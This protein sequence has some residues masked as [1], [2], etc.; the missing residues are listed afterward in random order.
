GFILEHKGG[1]GLELRPRLPYI[2]VG[3]LVVTIVVIS[4]MLVLTKPTTPR[5]L[6]VVVYA[7]S[8]T[9]T[10]IDPSVE[11]D[12]GLIVIG[13]VYETLTYYDHAT[14]E[15]KPRLAV[16]W[17]VN[18]DGTEWMFYLRR[19]VVFHDGTPFN[20]T[21]AKLSIER[22]RDIYRAEG[23]GLG[24]I[25]DAVEEIE[26]VDEYTIKFKLSYPQRLDL[27]AASTYAAYMFSPTALEKSGA[28]NYMDRKLED[29]FNAGNAIGTG[30][31]RLVHYDPKHEIKLEK[32]NEWWGW[33]EVSNPDAPDIIIIKIE[34]NPEAQYH[35]LIA[36]EIDIACCIPRRTVPL[37]I[38][39]GYRILNM[40]TFRNFL[41]FFNT[42]RYPT[43]ITYF[44]LAIAHTV[45][46]ELFVQTALMGM[47]YPAS[48]VIPRGFPGYVEK[49]SYEYNVTKAKE[50][51]EL[52]NV[53]LPLTIEVL[54]QVDYEETKAFAEFLKSTIE[55]ELGIR[56][57]LNPQSWEALRD[58]ARGIWENPEKTPHIIIADWWPTML[59]PYDYL[60]TMFHSESKAWNFAGY[61][62][63]ELDELIDEAWYLEGVDYRKA[64][65]MYIQAQ[66][67]IYREAV[68]IGLWD[69][70]RPYAYSPRLEVPGE[71]LS[72]FYMYVIRFELVKVRS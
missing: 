61:E 24:Y 54:Y 6:K 36:G 58:I 8:D 64:M 32:F 28:L 37:A 21:A 44:R 11:D 26:I 35:G 20:A 27:L 16:R 10:G 33:R 40:S 41:L 55:R 43:N 71:A 18:E 69:D 15:V 13:T 49:L 38:E 52:S 67:L 19:D 29:W 1:L 47:A 68:A 39:K 17:E 48:G 46:V 59:S 60:Y 34:R 65:E 22:A 72:P 3:V 42:R 9:I 50:Y 25:W 70:V 5:P 62:N 30:P 7:Y 2:I 51:L 53:K 14:G 66:Y 12:T 31:Y 56:V 4:L 45:N 57:E 23:R 63:L